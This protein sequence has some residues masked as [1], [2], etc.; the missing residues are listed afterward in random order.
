MIFHN[1]KI[2]IVDY[3]ADIKELIKRRF[4]TVGYNVFSTSSG[5]E[6]LVYFAKKQ[7]D[8]VILDLML[9]D[10]D[11]YELCRRI[12]ENSQVPIII[13]T[14]LGKVSDKL[15]GFRL[16]VDDYLTKPFSLKELEARIIS[17]FS[18]SIQQN[19]NSPIKIKKIF[20]IEDLVI[21]FNK[22]LIKRSDLCTELT[23]IEHDLLEFLIEN[24]GKKL[25]RI[26]ILNNV[27]GYIPLRFTDV[28]IVDVNISRLRAKIEKKSK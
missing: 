13:L 7:P 8:L 24:V 6:A 20:Q 17:I 22:R 27:W 11:G 5:K 3:E 1:K 14:S 4:L 25:S 9:P 18:R 10:L 23:E 12:R 2:L 26:N 28:R 19:Q 21:D 15:K 16:G